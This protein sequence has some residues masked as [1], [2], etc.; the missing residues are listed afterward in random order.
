[1][2]P[3]KTNNDPSL[4]STYLPDVMLTSEILWKKRAVQDGSNAGHISGTC[5]FYGFDRLPAVPTF[6]NRFGNLR[7]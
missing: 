2:S 4:H 6:T 7:H 1:M 5:P 3:T